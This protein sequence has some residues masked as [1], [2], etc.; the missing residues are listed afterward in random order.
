MNFDYNEDQ[1][2]LQDSINRFLAK[3][4]TF[5][6]RVGYSKSELGYSEE[7]WHTFAEIGLLALPFP[8][9]NDG[10]GGTAIET[11]LVMNALGKGLSL[12]PYLSTVILSGSIITQAGSPSQKAH[13]IPSIGAGELKIAFAHFEPHNRYENHITSTTAKKMGDI[14]K[15]NGHK[16]VVLHAQNA[17]QIILSARTS[18]NTDDAAGISLFIVDAHAPGITMR[19]Y[20]TQD[21]SRASEITFHDL[22]VSSD[23]LLGQLDQ[24]HQFIE[25]ALDAANA[26]LCS[27]AVGVM[28]ALFDLTLE[29]VKTR[30]QFG[31]PIGK[32]QALQH[33]LADMMMSVEQ[34]RSMAILAALAQDQQDAQK[35]SRDTSAAKAYICKAARHVGQEAIQLHGG[36]GV[37]DELSTSHYFKR[38]TMIGLTFGDYDY[39]FSKVSDALLVA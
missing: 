15:I 31:V 19:N 2:A 13:L 20:T 18:G 3:D 10:L 35:R 7:A 5:D 23:H 32:F 9:D 34:S 21:G 36:M 30:K 24:G 39:H 28:S 12:E 25:I 1:I 8:T 27:E 26:A 6:K 38:L 29:Y 33:R 14:W 17:H 22:E 4:Y 11:M 37:T 16:S